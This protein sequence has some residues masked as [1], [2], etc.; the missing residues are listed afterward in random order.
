[1]KFLQCAD[2]HLRGE[3]PICRT[4]EN[5]LESQ[6]KDVR[7]LV[8]TANKLKVPLLCLGDIFD[9]PRCA[10]AVVNMAIEEFSKAKFGIKFLPGNHDL[11]FHSYKLLQECSLGTLLHSFSELMDGTAGGHKWTA[12]PFGLDK[13]SDAEIRFIHRLVFPDEASRPIDEC[14]QTAEELLAEFPEQKWIFTGDYHHSFHFEKDGRHVV[15]TGCVNIQKADMIG[16]IPKV[17]VVDTDAGTIEWIPIPQDH[18]QFGT[19]YLEEAKGREARM[20][21]FF[22]IAKR[23]NGVT[24]SFKDNLEAN[25]RKAPLSVQQI[26]MEIDQGV[27]NESK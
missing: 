4:D 5:W 8:D 11:P 25:M 15:N 9:A 21:G 26:L 19:E 23:N 24:I 20:E 18:A 12:S 13:Q 2:I 1:M 6:R 3:I 22:E 17:A 10:T 16:Y 7:F 14:G 27:R